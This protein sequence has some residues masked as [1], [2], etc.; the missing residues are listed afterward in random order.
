V[1]V[2]AIH[3]NGSVRQLR[4]LVQDDQ[5]RYNADPMALQYVSFRTALVYLRMPVLQAQN[6]QALHLQ[7]IKRQ[8]MSQFEFGIVLGAGCIAF[9]GSL[10]LT[11]NLGSH[12]VKSMSLETV[13][14]NF[15]CDYWREMGHRTTRPSLLT[16]A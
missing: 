8:G 6:L 2:L 7:G 16:P 1:N 10:K 14:D 11:E 3:D 12:D 15:L 9:L 5:I 13:D 4:S